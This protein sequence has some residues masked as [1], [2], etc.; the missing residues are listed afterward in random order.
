MKNLKFILLLFLSVSVLSCSDDEDAPQF[1]LSNANIAGTYEIGSLT[2]EQKETATS[3]QG[4]EVDLATSSIV[5]A[6]FQVDLIL[7]ADGTFDA[8]GLY[9]EIVTSTP[10]GGATT[11]TEELLSVD[12][13]GTY[14]I[15]TLNNTI[16]FNPT[17][18]DFL[19]GTFNIEAF[20]Q[21]FVSIMQ[22]SETAEGSN[23]IYKTLNIGFTRE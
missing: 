20:T 8:E 2:G 1:L 19:A 6:N 7:T 9:R 17:T 13:E 3:S 11:Q 16:S 4:A 15:N 5:G 18:G 10:N 12:T 23:T 21:T 22:E 14:Q